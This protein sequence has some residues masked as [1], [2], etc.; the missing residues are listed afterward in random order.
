MACITNV[1]RT[2]KFGVSAAGDFGATEALVLSSQFRQISNSLN[3]APVYSQDPGHTGTPFYDS[4]GVTLDSKAATGSVQLQPRSDELATLLPLLGLENTEVADTWSPDPDGYCQYFRASRFVDIT[5]FDFYDC[6][7]SQWSIQSSKSSPRLTMDWGIEA[8]SY[9]TA[10]TWDLPTSTGFSQ[11]QPFVHTSS[12][13]NI[14]GTIIPIDDLNIS[15][16]NNLTTDLYYNSVTRTAL[17]AGR[18]EYQMTCTTPFND[19]A[20]D[21]YLTWFALEEASI[22]ASLVFMADDD[23]SRLTI[24]LP[25]IQG[26]INTPST[27]SGETPVKMEGIVWTARADLTDP[28]NIVPPI[29]VKVEY[30]STPLT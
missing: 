15:G 27:P 29:S 3:T 2:H 10:G 9:E 26:Q 24:T 8:C 20:N 6:K 30:G 4:A 1:P 19:E 12:V 25:K 22:S 13:I 7:T 28:E 18:Q 21:P 16:N 17:P 14:D 5:T 11:K 23:T